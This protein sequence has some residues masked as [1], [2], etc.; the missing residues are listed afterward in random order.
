[1]GNNVTDYQSSVQGAMIRHPITTEAIYKSDAHLKN[2]KE[3]MRKANFKLP[4]T[5][6][7][8]LEVSTYK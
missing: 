8:E 7:K 3:R 6:S 4:Y 2:Q 5:Q 1:M